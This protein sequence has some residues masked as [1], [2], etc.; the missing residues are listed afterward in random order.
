MQNVARGCLA[1][2][3][4]GRVVDQSGL[5][6]ASPLRRGELPAN[7]ADDIWIPVARASLLPVSESRLTKRQRSPRARRR[8]RLTQ[9]FR[10]LARH[11]RP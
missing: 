5:V 11:P 10:S 6:E 7:R 4:N 3:M 9:R 2:A 8:R 1:A